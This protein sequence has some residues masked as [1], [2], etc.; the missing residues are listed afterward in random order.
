MVSLFGPQPEGPKFCWV[1]KVGFPKE[2]VFELDC[3][4][5]NNSPNFTVLDLEEQF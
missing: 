1:S 5:Q 2:Y 3:G 4:S